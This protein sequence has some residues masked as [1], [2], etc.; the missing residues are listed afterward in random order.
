MHAV[1]YMF[2][3]LF[4]LILLFGS[5][6]ATVPYQPGR[7]IDYVHG[8]EM[9]PDEPQFV[10]GR[11]CRVLDAADWYWPGSLLSK[12]ILWNRKVDSHRIS[13]ETVEALKAYLELNELHHVKVRVNA[14][15]VADEWRRTFRNHSVAPGWRY[16]LGFLAWLQYTAFPGRFFGGD[17]YNPY[18]NT[19]N[20]YSDI[21]AIALHEGGHA[22][23]FAQREWKGTYAFSYMI[24]FVNLYHEALATSDA[25]GYLRAQDDLAMQKE[26]YNVL[27]PA[28]GTYIGGNFGEWLFFPW[29]YV[30]YAAGVIPGHVVGRVRSATLPDPTDP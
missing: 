6:C 14:Y 25:L 19:I 2:C 11:P 20:L 16:T 21:P 24:P 13:D 7:S 27:Y 18:S 28:Y 15:S 3:C 22:K 29:N 23:D 26:G 9:P 1:R 12:L 5:G 8:Y 30:A 17:N 10:Y 4:L